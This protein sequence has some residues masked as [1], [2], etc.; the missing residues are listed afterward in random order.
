MENEEVRRI[1]WHERSQG[2][3]LLRKLNPIM[4]TPE[5]FVNLQEVV[6]KGAKRK[7]GFDNQKEWVEIVYNESYVV[8]KIFSE[9]LLPLNPKD[10]NSFQAIVSKAWE[11][12]KAHKAEG[13]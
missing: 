1:Y 10:Y 13:K 7:Q 8:E 4:L 9:V 2:N 12:F 5:G 3:K 11:K 6:K